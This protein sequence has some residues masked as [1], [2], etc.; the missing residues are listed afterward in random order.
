MAALLPM[1]K[2]DLAKLKRAAAPVA[3]K[4]KTKA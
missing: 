2:L 4:R 3:R 1:K